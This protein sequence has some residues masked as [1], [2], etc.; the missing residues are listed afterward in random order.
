MIRNC[1]TC[2]KEFE[3]RVSQ[4]NKGVGKYC[5]HK[6]Q[7]VWNKGLKTGLVPKSAFKVGHKTWNKGKA[8][9]ADEKHPGWKGDEVKYSGL[10]R[11]ITKKKGKASF[12]TFD[13][14]HIANR[15]HW[16]NISREYKRDLADWM[17]LCPPCHFKYDVKDQGKYSSNTGRTWFKKGEHISKATE[18]KRGQQLSPATQFKKGQKP[19]NYGLKKI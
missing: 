17:S 13:K 2:Q 6:C 9:L 4:L 10:H 5:S 16:A 8:F 14:T 7:P 19:W 12:C 1:L 15:F 18:I 3:P 11:W